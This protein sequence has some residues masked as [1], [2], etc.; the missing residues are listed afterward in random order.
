MSDRKEKQKN[1][2]GVQEPVLTRYDL[3]VKRRQEQKKKEE[4]EKKIASAAG[5]LILIGLICL[6]LS[7]P[8]RSWLTVHGTY[9]IV[10]GEK[11]PRVEFDYNY[12]TALNNY[13]STNGYLLS[14][15]GLNLEGDLSTQMYSDTLSWKDYFDG[16]AVNNLKSGIAVKRDME[17]AG[18]TCDVSEEYESFVESLRQSAEAEGHSFKE[19]IQEFYGPYATL[20]R[21]EDYIRGDL[22]I[23]KYLD[24][25]AEKNAPSDEEI[26]TYYE[27][28][29][30]DYDCVDYHMITVNAELPTEPTEL[31]DPVEESGETDS[32][33]ADSGDTQEA[34]QPSQ[35]EI[36]A[37]ML[38]AK[39]EADGLLDTV[40]A[41]GEAYTNAPL[42]GVSY[43]L[44]EW[45]S[46]S[47]RKEGDT[48]VI[49]NTAAHCYYVL[50]FDARY[51]NPAVSENVRVIVTEDDNGQA[52]LD[53]WTAGEATEES[54]AALADQYNEN[55]LT[56]VEGGLLEGV[57]P[58]LLEEEVS[59]WL[60][61]GARKNGDTSVIVSPSAA[62]TYVFYYIGAGDPV[63]K[64]EIRDTLITNFK[65]DYVT[66]LA[67]N[68]TVEDPHHNLR[69]LEVQASQESAAA[70]SGAGEGE[71][72]ENTDGAGED[73]SEGNTDGAGED[74]SEGNTD[75]AGED[76]TEGNVD[77]AGEETPED[78]SAE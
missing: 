57:N 17:A 32:S 62:V 52:I 22:M 61:D 71:T 6:A 36:D 30:D 66:G 75:G 37:A 20:D 76:E 65:A 15:M 35:A 69:Y 33:A 50:S 29:S 2:E 44:S 39:K 59:A 67:E 73:E 13:V 14:L 48:T 78:S 23:S 3:K 25:V 45:L 28:N 34:Y 12:Y 24:S 41:E 4:R 74:E 27:E 49:E 53:E 26:Q 55:L 8:I 46:D 70:E 56:D 72:E 47:G 77:G 38:V 9:V 63:W 31:A 40:A 64:T 10:D 7:F 51:V 5:V 1:T 58:E 18:F 68:M 16:L 54:F 60:T 21:V 19:F 11:V 43:T 42:S